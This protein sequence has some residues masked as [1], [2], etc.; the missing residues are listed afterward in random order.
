MPD[1]ML[2][3]VNETD[4]VLRQEARS[5]VH[6]HGLWH[7]GAHVFLFDNGGRLLV[8]KRSANRRQYASLLD[9]SVSEHVKAGEDYL[10]GARRGLEEELSVSGLDPKPVATFRMV[11]GPGDNEISTFFHAVVDFADVQFDPEEIEAVAWLHVEEILEWMKNE[12]TA[13]CGWFVEIMRWYAGLPSTLNVMQEHTRA[14][15]FESGREAPGSAAPTE[16]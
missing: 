1:E 16:S 5:V 11:Y 15:F 9:C 8:Q 4:S 13:F 10:D 3:V 12:P 2:D 14:R 7:R 6:T